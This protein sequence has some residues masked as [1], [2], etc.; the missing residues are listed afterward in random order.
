MIAVIIQPQLRRGAGGGGT[1]TGGG[2]KGGGGGGL[3]SGGTDV[4]SIMGA[5]YRIPRAMT[6]CFCFAAARFNFPVRTWP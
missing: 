1:M 3:K 5:N 6:N 4:V 2:L